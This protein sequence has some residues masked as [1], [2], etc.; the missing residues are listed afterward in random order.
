MW[1]FKRKMKA[2]IDAERAS[3][4][5]RIGKGLVKLQ[6]AFANR[7]NAGAAKLSLP[8]IKRA[9]LLFCL[10]GGGLSIYLAMNGVLRSQTKT[11]VIQIDQ[12]SVPKHFDRSGDEVRE[13]QNIIDTDLYGPVKKFRAYID[14]L[15]I[16]DKK[17]YDSIRLSRPG[18]LDSV[19]AIEEIFLSQQIK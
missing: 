11:A 7:L 14:S 3:I 2:S 12:A 5:A 19:E 1:L 6:M 18:L 4:G 10:V 17:T 15:R 13:V 9:L 16:N 8:T